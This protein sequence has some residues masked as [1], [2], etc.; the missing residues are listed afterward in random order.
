M[1][2][3]TP[4]KPQ[5]STNV[6]E[7]VQNV[8][9]NLYSDNQSL[10]TAARPRSNAF[11]ENTETPRTETNSLES[12]IE[13]VTT[14]IENKAF[15]RQSWS[16]MDHGLMNKV[17]YPRIA[18][19]D[20]DIT[21]LTNPSEGSIA[22]I[23]ESSSGTLSALTPM[24]DRKSI[25]EVLEEEVAGNT[26]KDKE[27]G[28]NINEEERG[29]VFK[30]EVKGNIFKE[31]VIVRSA[32]EPK[33]F[34][35]PA[36]QNDVGFDKDVTPMGSPLSNSICSSMVSSVYQNSGLDGTKEDS[37]SESSPLRVSE[38]MAGS[39]RTDTPSIYDSGI[40]SSLGKDKRTSFHDKSDSASD[41]NVIVT[42]GAGVE[43]V[44]DGQEEVQTRERSHAVYEH[45]FTHVDHHLKLHLMMNVFDDNEEFECILKVILLCVVFSD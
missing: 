44:E 17:S 9:R 34:H 29:N 12:Q 38:V 10:D 40:A 32:S 8:R 11:V 6:V 45:P 24:E 15:R 7:Q 39:D 19:Q 4:R 18:S 5:T 26:I 21:I 37:K 36:E 43:L 25:K 23:S 33:Q 22:V 28:N 35:I 16:D 20:S 3:S 41:I 1:A 42:E 30:E 31:E 2:K 14:P 27:M 13:S